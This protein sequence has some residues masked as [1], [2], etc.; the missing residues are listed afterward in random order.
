[1]RADIEPVARFSGVLAHDIRF[2][3]FD[4]GN[5]VAYLSIQVPMSAEGQRYIR[6]QARGT[7]KD[8]LKAKGCRQG[9]HLMVF[10]VLKTDSNHDAY[11]AIRMVGANT[12]VDWKPQP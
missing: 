11:V 4:D 8:Y 1:M 2:R 12:S 7:A 6:A 10:G 9:Q 3:S 5:E